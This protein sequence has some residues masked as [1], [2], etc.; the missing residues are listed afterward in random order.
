MPKNIKDPY[1]IKDVYHV[2]SSLID[3]AT[4]VVTDLCENLSNSIDTYDEDILNSLKKINTNKYNSISVGNSADGIYPIWAGVDANNKVRKIFVSINSS[5][6]DYDREK[7]RK[8]VSWSWNKTDL[9]DQFFSK[10]SKSKRK[11]IFDM[12]VKSNAIAIAD[13]SGNFT[14]DHHEHITESLN[15]KHFKKKRYI[16]K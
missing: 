1:P 12:E 8:L 4:V 5:N 7:T 14:Y 9:N 10:K 16:S 3:A 2:T 13:H 15:E 6:Y 11:K